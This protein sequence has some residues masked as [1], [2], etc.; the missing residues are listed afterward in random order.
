MSESAKLTINPVSNYIPITTN[1]VIEIFKLARGKIYRKK[2]WIQQVHAR[3]AGGYRLTLPEMTAYYRG[4]NPNFKPTCFC[5]LGALYAATWEYSKKHPE[6]SITNVYYDVRRIFHTS[7]YKIR[8]GEDIAIINDSTNHKTI[9]K[10]YNTAIKALTE[11]LTES[12][13]NA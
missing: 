4:L 3:N 11:T 2:N 12:Q 7:T 6:L 10:I 13:T 9:I 8:K 5:A 1:Q